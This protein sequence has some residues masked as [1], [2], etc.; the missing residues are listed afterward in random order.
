M[1]TQ[2]FISDSNFIY[3]SDNNKLLFLPIALG[4]FDGDLIKIFNLDYANNRNLESCITNLMESYVNY[5]AYS[6]NK[7]YIYFL[8]LTNSIGYTFIKYLNTLHFDINLII[9][10]GIIYSIIINIGTNIIQ[11]KNFNLI[12]PCSY[13]ISIFLFNN[14]YKY[15]INDI[16]IFTLY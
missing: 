7:I 15:I 11:I 6:C 13:K 10:N 3:Y 4:L 1:K 16:T 8:N 14:F 2:I 12:L 9:Q 5:F